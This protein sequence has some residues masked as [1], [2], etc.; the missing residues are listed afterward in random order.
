MPTYLVDLQLSKTAFTVIM[1][2]PLVISWFMIY[3]SSVLD[4][5]SRG[6]KVLDLRE[7]FQ[8]HEVQELY[9]LYGPEGRRLYLYVELVDFGYMISYTLLLLVLFSFLLKPI[10]VRTANMVMLLPLTVALADVVENICIIGMLMQFPDIKERWSSVGSAANVF[11]W[12]VFYYAVAPA[13]VILGAHAVGYAAGR[14]QKKR[15]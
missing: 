1:V 9:H 14:N 10:R 5:Y 2:L 8:L 3:I 11:K 7:G 12:K 6:Q 13:G 4:G 15:K